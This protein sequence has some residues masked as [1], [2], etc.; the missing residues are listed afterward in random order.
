[1]DG[2]TNIAVFSRWWRAA[3]EALGRCVALHRTAL[4]EQQENRLLNIWALLDT[5]GATT[6]VVRK[7]VHLA[8]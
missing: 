2:L 7:S 8:G 5:N 4:A 1:M 6:G 3:G